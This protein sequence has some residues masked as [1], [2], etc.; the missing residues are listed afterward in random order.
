[1]HAASSEDTCSDD[2]DAAA[3]AGHELFQLRFPIWRI[4]FIVVVV[5]V[6]RSSFISR[7]GFRE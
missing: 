3:A 1:M 2:D 4:H 5:G 6:G 7:S